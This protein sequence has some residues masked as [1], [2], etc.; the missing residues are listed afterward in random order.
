MSSKHKGD[1]MSKLFVVVVIIVFMYVILSEMNESTPIM[2][3]M[4]LIPEL[5]NA[6]VAGIMFL[7]GDIDMTFDQI[8]SIWP[9]INTGNT[10]F[11]DYMDNPGKLKD[12]SFIVVPDPET[13]EIMLLV[14]KRINDPVL[15]SKMIGLIGGNLFG[16]TGHAFTE[17]D[18]Y[19]YM[20]VK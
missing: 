2:P 7:S 5:R 18:G 10:N 6:R 4:S 9:G 15:A 1:N 12:Y 16:P 20:R 13:S 8:I 17:T 11:G 3:N 14:G 19:V